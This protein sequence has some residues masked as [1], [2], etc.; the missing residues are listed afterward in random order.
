MSRLFLICLSIIPLGAWQRNAILPY[1][2]PSDKAQLMDLANHYTTYLEG[3]SNAPTSDVVFYNFSNLIT[4][5]GSDVRLPHAFDLFSA[6]E[7]EQGEAQTLISYLDLIKEK[8]KNKVEVKFENIY[9][10]ECVEEIGRER[11]ALI[12]A[13]KKLKWQKDKSSKPEERTERILI[14]IDITRKPFSIRY[15]TT[16]KDYNATKGKKCNLDQNVDK[17]KAQDKTEFDAKK[18]KADE[19]FKSG[20]YINAIDW[21]NE[22]LK[23]EDSD[24][25]AFYCLQQ[26]KKCNEQLSYAKY[27]TSANEL[28][29]KGEYSK[30]KSIYSKMFIDYPE[31]KTLLKEMID[32]CDF[33]IIE[34]TFN[35]FKADG[36]AYFNRSLFDKAKETYSKA[37][38][39]KP[40]DQTIIKKLKDCDL[41]DSRKVNDKLAEARGLISRNTK[42]SYAEAI[43]LYT[44]YEPSG[45]LAAKDYYVIA[46]VMDMSYGKVNKLLGYSRRQSFNLSKEYCLKA[47]SMGSNEAANMWGVRFNSR[48]RNR[49]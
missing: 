35:R 37:L 40:N 43:K 30:A 14:S 45:K 33:G 25:D 13:D 34:Q 26:L 15:V 7:D 21:Y 22:A 24:T 41:G 10:L 28:F 9:L 11:F 46:S 3:Y 32:K 4:M 19:L 8:Y 47:K 12:I 29:K 20:R 16:E 42:E 6:F 27:E 49:K 23:Y 17:K 1:T 2:D 38:T 18:S 5:F 36:D 31:K 48:S 39:F 44:Y